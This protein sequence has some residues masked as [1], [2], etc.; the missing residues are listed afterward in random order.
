MADRDTAP[1]VF[2]A[3]AEWET[4]L[5]AHHADASEAWLRIAKRRSRAPGLTIEEALDGAL[6]FGWIDG[7]RRSHDDES[8]L[9][10]YS[11][12]RRTSSWSRVNVDKFDALAAAGRVRPAGFAAVEEARADGRWEAAY[13]SQRTAEPP[14]DL[15]AALAAD[16]RAAEAFA[17]LDRTRRYAVILEVLKA[18]TPERRATVVA[19]AVARLAPGDG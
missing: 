17:A 7:Q 3:G 2:S 6:C 9:Q 11:P 8:F 16:P 13:A 10:R 4:W 18:R 14:A 5:E 12:R 1:L 15:L 19:R